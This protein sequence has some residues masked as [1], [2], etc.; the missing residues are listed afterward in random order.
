MTNFVTLQDDDYP[1]TAVDDAAQERTTP[2]KTREARLRSLIDHGAWE[3]LWGPRPDAA[4]IDASQAMADKRN[5]DA[6]AEEYRQ[7]QVRQNQA[8]ADVCGRL[9]PM[10]NEAGSAIDEA[11]MPRSLMSIAISLRRIADALEARGGR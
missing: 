4:E 2:D 8:Y 3:P 1:P 11:D 9:E 7:H 5:R 10:V 6:R